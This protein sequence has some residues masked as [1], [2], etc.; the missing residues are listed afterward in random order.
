[1]TTAKSDSTFC[2]GSDVVVAGM[3]E[4]R[5]PPV[6]SPPPVSPFG[7]RHGPQSAALLAID[8][9]KASLCQLPFGRHAL[10][11]AHVGLDATGH[12]AD[13]RNGYWPAFQDLPAICGRS[14]ARL[15]GS[16]F[17]RD[18]VRIYVNSKDAP[19]PTKLQGVGRETK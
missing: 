18:G 12:A 19:W 2:L 14:P 5:M 17:S 6:S 4:Q 15:I 9:S 8:P 13:K 7:W 3:R 16:M 10:L 1:M 11:A